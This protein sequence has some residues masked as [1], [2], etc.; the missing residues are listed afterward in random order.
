M[1][2][3]VYLF[4]PIA[5]VIMKVSSLLAYSI[6]VLSYVNIMAA[7]P[8]THKL[9]KRS[10]EFSATSRLSSF[11]ASKENPLQDMVLV[12]DV[13]AK[14]AD[15]PSSST[16]IVS[17]DGSDISYYIDAQ[18]GSDKQNF[19]IVVD[20][21]S[22]YTWVYG[23]NC[24]S[25]VCA[26][27]RTYDRKNSTTASSLP[28]TFKIQYSSGAVSG[29]VINDIISFSGFDTRADFGLADSAG[30]TFSSFPIDGIMGLSAKDVSGTEF[31]GIITTLY[32]QSLIEKKLFGVNLGRS[33]DNGDEGSI[34]FGGVDSEKY[35]GDIH[36][37]PVLDESVLWNI[38]LTSTFMGPYQVDF[39]G[40][41]SAIVDTG[42]TLLVLPPSDALKL[43]S[44]I[45]GAETDGTNYAVPCSTNITLQLQI[46]GQNWTIS[47]KDYVGS[48]L[49]SNS[50]YCISNIQGVSSQGNTTWILGDVFLKNVY[51]VFDV[52]NQR[53]GFASKVVSSTNATPDNSFVYSALSAVSS[54]SATA[55]SDISV[56]VTAV[57]GNQHD[58]VSS[59]S[60]SGTTTSV[61]AS[62]STSANSGST[63]SMRTIYSSAAAASEA[64]SSAS[65]SSSTS[66]ASGKV[67]ASF[68]SGLCVLAAL[69]VLAW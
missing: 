48:S 3:C 65:R 64:A 54:Q 59:K 51:S 41:R 1:G 9:H 67:A 13:L 5:S 28:Y 27:H 38:N 10:K 4:V 55:T 63:S 11:T 31:P 32:N 61:S 19:S 39:G 20:T 35:S 23:S 18:L 46:A 16:G 12:A 60:V 17:Q 22:Y 52:D 8:I 37:T 44:Y 24:T 49:Q 62:T 33:S 21:G 45:K 26:N 42:T 29:S 58:T 6:Y 69:M 34:T 47:P 53:V 30:S 14:R 15:S 66:S 68:N 25:E 7:E 2:D 57:G 56:S 36:Y 40:P 50:D 43:H